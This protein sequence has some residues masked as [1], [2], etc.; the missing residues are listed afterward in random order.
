MPLRR[1][2]G[3]A[4]AMLALAI[5]LIWHTSLITLNLATYLRYAPPLN[6]S[7]F[8]ATATTGP[9]LVFGGASSSSDNSN[10]SA[11]A[12]SSSLSQSSTAASQLCE[13]GV[14]YFVL[15][16]TAIMAL[17]WL[18]RKPLQQF[19]NYVQPEWRP[20]Y[21]VRLPV[22][23]VVSLVHMAWFIAGQVWVSRASACLWHPLCIVA[24]IDILVIYIAS[25]IRPLTAAVV[26][27]CATT[28]DADPFVPFDAQRARRGGLS[29][30][31]L[32]SLP[33]F[34]FRGP[35]QPDAD[36]AA[37]DGKNADPT[38][39]A[40]AAEKEAADAAGCPRASESAVTLTNQPRPRRRS[41]SSIRTRTSNNNNNNNNPPRRTSQ[42][43][44]R[45]RAHS[46][47][48]AALQPLP[49]DVDNHQCA[50]CY[51]DYAPG[52]R[53]RRLACGHCFH[54]NCVDAWLVAPGQLAAP[55]PTPPSPTTAPPPAAAP[56]ALSPDFR[57]RRT[58]PMCVQPAVAADGPPPSRRTP[59]T[60]E[61]HTMSQEWAAL[62]DEVSADEAAGSA[63]RVRRARRR[64]ARAE[65]AAARA[66][67]AAER[68]GRGVEAAEEAVRAAVA[69]EEREERA[70]GGGDH[71]NGGAMMPAQQ[72]QQLREEEEVVGPGVDAGRQLHGVLTVRMHPRPATPPP[73]AS[74]LL[75]APSSSSRLSPTAAAAARAALPVVDPGVDGHLP[76]GVRRTAALGRGRARAQGWTGGPGGPMAASSLSVHAA[77]QT[78]LGGV[79][80]PVGGAA[81]AVTEAAAAAA[82][83]AEAGAE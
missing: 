3:K 19:F 37:T 44:R 43:L 30:K 28:D 67:A 5:D 22:W 12:S 21:Q 45:A 8:A 47:G 62:L 9:T 72:Q 34:I 41:R 61:I 4:A 6:P 29:R 51:D 10:S 73:P 80:A 81:V 77:A 68:A 50:I 32:R 17:W 83:V 15:G 79:R 7:A 39:A 11:A 24:L 13:V 25:I 53:V 40:A 75:L 60:R 26:G 49:A 16:E 14:A 31:E 58:C 71:R 48:S 35:A 36:A 38:A 76:E 52:D 33:A 65:R 57:P 27:I 70:A 69:E 74:G 42:K 54:A 78:D 2:V 20:P 46:A 82:A 59:R 1:P 63:A 56:A 18:P 64:R 23:T 66:R 55:T